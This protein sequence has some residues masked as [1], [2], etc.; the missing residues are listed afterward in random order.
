MEKTMRRERFGKPPNPLKPSHRRTTDAKLALLRS[1]TDRPHCPR[2]HRPGRFRS[3]R[4]P[5]L[6]AR[7]PR[8]PGLLPRRR[9]P[10]CTKQL[11]EFRDDWSH[12][13]ARHIE[14]FGVNPQIADH[15][16]KFRAKFHF[17]FPLLVEKICE[18]Y[19]T[20]GSIVKRTVYLIGPD[21]QDSLRKTRDA[22]TEGSPVGRPVVSS[23]ILTPRP[24]R[25]C[26][27]E[28]VC[29]AISAQRGQYPS[30]SFLGSLVCC[31]DRLLGR[32]RGRFFALRRECTPPS[33]IGLPRM[34]LSVSW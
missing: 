4:D 9:Y 21:W 11:C 6:P 8:G 25:I 12:A 10:G 30:P 23:A 20:H 3:N 26:E 31:R 14:V 2:L 29:V 1:T 7:S 27:L 34:P 17:P 32:S 5:L 16:K 22:F 19:H 13:A 24:D 18:P 15:H 33:S 28:D